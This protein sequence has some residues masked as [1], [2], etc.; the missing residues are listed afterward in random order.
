MSRPR[1]WLLSGYHADSHAAWADWLG[2]TFEQFDWQLHSLP[3]RHFRWRIRGNPLSWLDSLHDAPDLLIATSMVDLATLKG[4]HPQLARVPS[5]Y[6]F[7]ENQFAYPRSGQQHDSVDPQMV[8]LYGA[9]AADRVLF[10]SAFNRDSLLDGVDGLLQ[11]LPD[12]VPKGICERLQAKSEVLPVPIKPLAPASKNSRLIVWNHRWEYDKAPQLFAD[13]IALLQ[14]RGVDFQLALLGGRSEA[15]HPALAQLRDTAGAHILVD[16]KL[17]S[18][19]Y[20]TTLASAAI[21]VSTSLHEFQGLAMLEAA[22]GGAAPLVP[23][24]LCYREQYPQACRYR[25]GDVHSLAERLQDWLEQGAPP[26]IDVSPW[27]ERQL[28][29]RWRAALERL[30]D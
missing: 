5:L 18:E 3:G 30:L 15:P 22:S 27:S 11:R 17:D 2:D 4:L 19:A 1:I 29:P 21:A 14:Q 7:H 20:R 12:R 8:Q 6:Y 10:N 25:A 13:A 16:G 9:L 23:D 24:D 28:T 26:A